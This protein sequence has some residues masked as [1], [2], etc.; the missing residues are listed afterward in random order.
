[1]NQTSGTLYD[2]RWNEVCPSLVLLRALRV[3]VMVRVLVLAMAGVMLT[4]WG[5]S[6]VDQIFATAAPQL[7]PLDQSSNPIDSTGL[8]HWG[9][10]LTRAWVWLSEPFVHMARS[11]SIRGETGWKFSLA[12]CFCALWTIAVWALFGGAI[13]R[14]A[15]LHLTRLETLG[16]LTAL[17]E[18]SQKWAASAGAPLIP[19]V[20]SALLAIPLMFAGL[21]SRL[22]FFSLILGL[23][24]VFVILWSLLLAVI[25]VGM[26]VGWPLM[27]ATIGVERTD[28]FDGVSRCYAYV[29]QRP[30]HLV[31]YVVIAAALGWLGQM[32]VEYF[33]L[34]AVAL[35]EWAVSWGAGGGRIAELT[36]QE[37]NTLTG[38]AAIGAAGIRF[39]K[40]ALQLLVASYAPAYL[41]S[42]AVG[43]YLLL[44]RQV[45]STEMDEVSIEESADALPPLHDDPSGVPGTEPQPT[46]LANDGNETT[47]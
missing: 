30:L 5:W 24:W 35:G 16:P 15:A 20:G 3:S 41:W 18:A 6:L 17:K 42:A 31:C 14:I 22:D 38:M 36:S 39:W 44:R 37:G 4:Q 10:P 13:A 12:L 46:T 1:M 32:A 25:L 11:E 45:D 40:E 34:A 9:G 19:L 29:Y 21:L 23:V 33:A 8:I 28:A 43:I 27:W 47:N 26:F 7:S 2:I